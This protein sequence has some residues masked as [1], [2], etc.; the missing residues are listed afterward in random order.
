MCV[1]QTIGTKVSL[2]LSLVWISWELTSIRI[3]CGF[4]LRAICYENCSWL[5]V[6]RRGS[7]SASDCVYRSWLL[8]HILY[9]RVVGCGGVWCVE[10]I[11]LNTLQRSRKRRNSFP[12]LGNGLW[13]ILS[14]RR[15]CVSW[16]SLDVNK[17]SSTV[18]AIGWLSSCNAL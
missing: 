9:G 10:F 13:S 11:C 15:N 7:G 14:F 17:Y 1:T 8:T 6:V 12:T 4:A 3:V 16:S 2:S 18:S 5:E